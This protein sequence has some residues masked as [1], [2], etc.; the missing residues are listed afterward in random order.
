MK[1]IEALAK[2]GPIFPKI[3]LGQSITANTANVAVP[4]GLTDHNG[5]AVTPSGFILSNADVNNA[6]VRRGATAADATNVYITNAH[7]TLAVVVD[8]FL[9]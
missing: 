1:V 4:H 9:F 5:K 2:D 3:L 7:A 6:S 8:I